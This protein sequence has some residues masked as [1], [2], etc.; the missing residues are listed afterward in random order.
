MPPRKRPATYAAPD[1]QVGEQQNTV[2]GGDINQ[3]DPRVLDRV[4]RFL[5][6]DRHSRDLFA[7]MLEHLGNQ[8]DAHEIMQTRRDQVDVKERA[9]RREELD[10]ALANLRQGQAI[11]RRWLAGLTLAMAVAAAVVAWL[12]W[13]ELGLLAARA[14]YDVALSVWRP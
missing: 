12:L 4:L 6:G 13:R 7:A 8:L 2:A 10:A 9:A 1:Q 5:E 14:A 11:A 3:V